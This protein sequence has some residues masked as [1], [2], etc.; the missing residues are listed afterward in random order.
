MNA[1]ERLAVAVVLVVFALLVFGP[2]GLVVI[3]PVL[4]APSE[5]K[6]LVRFYR[7]LRKHP[8]KGYAILGSWVALMAWLFG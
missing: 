7:F 5:G 6:D 4:F 3:L 1:N 2:M 8:A